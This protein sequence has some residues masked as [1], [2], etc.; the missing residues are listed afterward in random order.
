[1]A[2]RVND[3]MAAESDGAAGTAADDMGIGELAARFGL[4][5][6]VLRHWEDMG[7]LLPARDSGG[8][9]RYDGRH[10]TQVAMILLGK[11][12]GLSLEQLGRLAGRT[13]RAGR[14]ALLEE[15]RAALER[16]IAAARASLALVTHALDC[17]A[18]DYRR[19]PEFRGK[20]ATFI[21]PGP[22]DATD[23]PAG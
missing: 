5:P 23:A 13:D 12:G 1:M 17:P 15:H 7:L 14:R 21:P 3:G 4:A 2:A 19:C 8:R 18:E 10:L 16:R 11:R 6:H 20:V 22:G 9:R